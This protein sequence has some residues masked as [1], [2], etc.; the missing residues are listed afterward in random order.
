MKQ[1]GIYQ[2]LYDKYIEKGGI[3]ILS[4]KQAYWATPDNLK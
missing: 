4:I 2:T 1:E 3:E